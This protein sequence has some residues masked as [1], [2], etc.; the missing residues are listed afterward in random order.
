MWSTLALLFVGL[1][2]PLTAIG[3]YQYEHTDRIYQGVS[4]L[5]LNLS[6][7]T[8]AEADRALKTRAEELTA[9]PVLVRAE[10]LQLRTDW[11]QLGLRLPTEALLDRAMAVGR[12]GSYFQRVRGQL[13][14]LRFGAP[15]VAEQSVDDGA[16]AQFASGIHGQLERP[17]RNAR[18][19]LKPDLTLELTTAQVGRGLDVDDAVRR[20][21]EAA[22]SGQGQVDLAV[23]KILPETT[24]EMRV[25]AK[26]RAEGILSTPLSLAFRDRRW[27]IERQELADIL[28]FNGG[29]G[30]PIEVKLDSSALQAR[31]QAIAKEINQPAQNARLDWNGGQPKVIRPSGEGRELDPVSAA[32]MIS[33]R[34]ADSERTIALPVKVTAPAVDASKLQSMGLQGLIDSS[35]T[36]FQGSVPQ[37]AHNIKLAA[38]RL[39]GVVV[40]PRTTFSFN[41]ELGPTTVANG[42]QV[43]FGITS[44]GDQ[45]KTVPSVAGGICQ[46]ATTLFQPVFWSGYQIEERNWHLYWI[47]AYTSRGAVGLD[48]TVDEEV[49]LDL[50]FINNTDNFLLIQSRTDDTNVT[51]ELYGTKPTWQIKVDGPE[52]T[53]RK[54]AD[55]T[56][57]NEPEPSLPEGQRLQV[58][59]AREGFTATFV[60]TVTEPGAPVRTLKLESRY[61]P[62]R[63]VTLVG[64]G[65]RAP[66][67]APANVNRPSPAPPGRG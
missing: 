19:E 21:R 17:V 24:D 60:R 45:H 4:A 49:N 53:D 67:A 63:N 8:W 11:R 50:Q 12:N 58:E 16:L 14:A 18:L 23:T 36:A 56:P 43:A 6:G 15:V 51:F 42:Y 1:L 62:S 65:G 5:G 48:A 30:V 34:A 61:V 54:P 52:I 25:P 37:K 2:A 39:H 41:R 7:M 32:Q 55:P 22:L 44:A 59:T 28:L 64:T 38:S 10:E 57:V 26:E 35:T 46:V 27:T 9:R 3:W 47:P 20:L 66:S 33:E 13:E 31:V 40:A 29:P